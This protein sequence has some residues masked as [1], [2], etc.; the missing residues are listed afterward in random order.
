MTYRWR[1]CYYVPSS[2]TTLAGTPQ[3]FFCASFKNPPLPVVGPIVL[4]PTPQPPEFEG[5]GLTS[6]EIGNMEVLA[7]IDSIAQALPARFSHD[8]LRSVD[9]HMKALGQSLGD[10]FELSRSDRG[11][12]PETAIRSA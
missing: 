11:V 9:V 12:G 10:G 7:A 5:T 1:I 8:I 6:E 3:T 4:R 2:T